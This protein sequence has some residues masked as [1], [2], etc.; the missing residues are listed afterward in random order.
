[1]SSAPISHDT[2][3]EELFFRFERALA[4]GNA[5]AA[6]ALVDEAL[7]GDMEPVSLLGDVITPAQRRI[8]ERWQ[9]GEWSVAQ[10]HIATGISLAAA[11][12]VARRVR[13]LPITKGR[14]IVGCAEREWHA[15]AAMVVATC[16]RARGWQVTFLGAATPAER[17]YSYLH[18]VE[19]DVV[20]VSCS[21]AGGL[22]STRRGI[23]SATTAGIPVLVGG[24]AFGKDARRARA[25]GATAW[26]PTLRE[27]LD[28]ADQLPATVDPVSPLPQDVVF[29]QRTLDAEHHHF[30]RRISDRW[31]PARV[32]DRGDIVT[33]TDLTLV[34]RDCVEQPLRT[35]EGALLTGDGRLVR[36]AATWV[37]NVLTSRAVPVS[38]V[39][40][41]RAEVLDVVRSL[42]RTRAMTEQN[43]PPTAETGEPNENAENVEG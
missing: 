19:P 21:V 17:L 40:A 9:R 11:E 22:P 36:D 13:S 7:D 24:A 12:A 16:L 8:G 10:E 18:Q 33:D 39:D 43:W 1:M 25:L 41:L 27:G 28:L 5:S 30:A 37:G 26:A 31:E 6:V 3:F 23:E 15:L 34:I 2:G 38:A 29:E 4:E 14:I 32:V 20:A 35:L 42:P